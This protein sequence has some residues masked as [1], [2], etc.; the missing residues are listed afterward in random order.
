MPRVRIEKI[1][2]GGRGLARMADGM[3]VMVPFV[4]PGELVEIE[5]VRRF[6]GHLEAQLVTIPEPSPH[7]RRPACPLFGTCGGC[8]LQHADGEHQ[9]AIRAAMVREAMA[10]AGVG[11]DLPVPLPPCSR[12]LGYRHRIRLHLAADSSLGFHRV[13]SNRVVAIDT[14]PVATD[15]INR[16]IGALRAHPALL[17]DLAPCCGE[18]ELLHSPADDHLAMVLHL[19]PRRE[20]PRKTARR[21]SGL[22]R[23]TDIAIETRRGRG[24]RPLDPDTAPFLLRQVFDSGT[25]HTLAWDSGCFFQANAGQNPFLVELVC[26][27]AG[28]LQDCRLLE[29]HCGMGNFSI[30]LALRGARITGVEQN[31][32]AVRWAI[33]NSA[34]AGIGDHSFLRASASAALARM[35]GARTFD[36]I[37]LDP[38]RQGLARDEAT[39]LAELGVPR[40]VHVSCDPATLA[41][42][43]ARLIR[44]GYHLV[45]LECVDMFPQTH[46]TESV[47]LLEKN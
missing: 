35:Q 31:P 25:G 9:A 47:A 39:L 43:L 29:L 18:I 7:R 33:R 6:R 41:R 45:R 10:R 13:R 3:V 11:P 44:S 34:A 20:L 28:D 1:I 14:C 5:V 46:H 4:L 36:C 24:L 30:P 12:P 2:A 26:A 40:I 15:A 42:D 17:A 21:L 37:V 22:G 16:V 19:R 23:Q 8:D 38:P 27:M 32:R